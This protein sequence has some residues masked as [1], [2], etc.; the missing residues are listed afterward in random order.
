M[1]PS[2]ARRDVE[3]R[4]V[5]RPDTQA[6]PAHVTPGRSVI[7]LTLLG[8]MD[9]LT[10]RR[11][12]ASTTTDLGRRQ[13]V[14]SPGRRARRV[15]GRESARRLGGH[16]DDQ[17]AGRR[18]DVGRCPA[19]LGA[20]AASARRRPRAGDRPARPVRWWRSPGGT[21]S[22][23]ATFIAVALSSPRRC[24][25]TL[26]TSCATIRRIRRSLSGCWRTVPGCSR[27][28]SIR[29]SRIA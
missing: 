5:P 25:S 24:G 6:S 12:P 26:I 11:L 18:L 15:G 7:L 17:E 4:R 8:V 21:C 9:A 20:S 29:S 1:P 2:V 3:R 22:P 23:I 13:D 28:A 27:M 16:L 14:T 19:D 10:L